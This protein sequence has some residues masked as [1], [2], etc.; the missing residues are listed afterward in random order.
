MTYRRRPSALHAARA[1]AGIAYCAALGAAALLAAGPLV[2]GGVLLAIAGAGIAA[3]A[4][5]DLRRAARIAVPLGLLIALANALLIR[6]GLTVIWRFGDVPLLG[7]LDVTLEAAVSGAVLGLRAVALVLAASLYAVAV[8]P[9]EVL[10]LFR[11]ISFRSALTATLATHHGATHAA[12]HLHVAVHRLHVFLHQLLAEADRAGQ[13]RD[14]KA[15][16]LQVEARD[17][18]AEFTV[19]YDDDMVLLRRHGGRQLRFPNRG[20]RPGR[21]PLLAASAC[22]AARTCRSASAKSS[23]RSDS[24]FSIVTIGPESET[25]GFMRC[26]QVA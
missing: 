7:P 23:L 4:G 22:W 16:F 15:G 12:H 10:R 25:G 17:F 9:D 13:R 21:E 26:R 18:A 20:S 3:G 14:L 24:R 1:G 5:A 8:D 11:R 19:V 6:D 2:L